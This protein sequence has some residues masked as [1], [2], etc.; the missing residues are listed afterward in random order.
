MTS[1]REDAMDDTT[2]AQA[3]AEDPGWRTE[4]A[5]AMTEF[6]TAERPPHFD[7]SAIARTVTASRRARILVT[8]GA[9]AA[10]AAAVA[11]VVLT[12]GAGHGTRPLPPATAT[13]TRSTA[14]AAPIDSDTVVR[15][16]FP[17]ATMYQD[18]RTRG[19]VDLT[20]VRALF[21]DPAA[22]A[23][24][25]GDGGSGVT[26]G[27]RA[28]GV[29]AGDPTGVL[30]Y[31]GTT[32]LDRR[33][34]LALDPV[35]GRITGITCGARRGDPGDPVVAGRYGRAT[36]SG[37][38]TTDCGRPAPTTWLA[39]EPRSGTVVHGWTVT[40]DGATPFA[41]G[42]DDVQGTVHATCPS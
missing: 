15:G 22:F 5:A 19:R 4:L 27:Q 16:L 10:A 39:D 30:F 23:T 28:D 41:L 34:S 35:S 14:P 1:E 42:V 31:R 6:A 37:G 3:A 25:W 26:C 38:G 18:P 11:A 2:S 8:A 13:P 24:V 17:A 36:G 9:A 7:P 29:L 12:T 32:L 40:L 20:R 33:A 21:S